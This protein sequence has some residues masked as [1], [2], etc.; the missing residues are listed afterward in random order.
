MLDEIRQLIEQLEPEGNKDKTEH[1]S[2]ISNVYSNVLFNNE[3]N[4]ATTNLLFT[5]ISSIYDHN[6]EQFQFF[7][8]LTSSLDNNM[9]NHLRGVV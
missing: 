5:I 8:E 7:K 3:V 6:T 1:F 4:K 9:Q 2:Q